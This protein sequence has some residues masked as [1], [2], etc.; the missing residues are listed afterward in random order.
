MDADEVR[1]GGRRESMQTYWLNGGGMNWLLLDAERFGYDDGF[2]L[3]ER[4][5]SAR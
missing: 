1:R 2:R 3:C 4:R 5:R